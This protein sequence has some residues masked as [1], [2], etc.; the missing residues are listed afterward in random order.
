MEGKQSMDKMADD[1]DRQQNDT[2][3]EQQ[4]KE[5]I[6]AVS[7]N[8]D[9]VMTVAMLPAWL[10]CATTLIPSVWIFLMVQMAIHVLMVIAFAF[11]YHVN[12]KGM[13]EGLIRFPP[14]YGYRQNKPWKRAVKFICGYGVIIL[15]YVLPQK[16]IGWLGRTMNDW[17]AGRIGKSP[18]VGMFETACQSKLFPWI[19]ATVNAFV[20]GLLTWMVVMIIYGICKAIHQERLCK[21]I[22]WIVIG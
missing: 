21:F 2:F 16:L 1:D 9:K 15:V 7:I 20:A 14:V 12:L 4:R 10:S 5:Q 8:H 17:L 13:I 22:P 6:K 19:G 18:L 11:L 3:R